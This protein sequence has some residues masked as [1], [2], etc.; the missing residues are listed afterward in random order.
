MSVMSNGRE[1][2][3]EHTHL[4]ALGDSVNIGEDDAIE[5]AEKLRAMRR[6]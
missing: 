4:E 3:Q 5:I 1:S 6:S 2:R